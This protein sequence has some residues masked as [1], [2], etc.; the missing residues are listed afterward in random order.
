MGSQGRMHGMSPSSDLLL[1]FDVTQLL[2]SLTA[3][4]AT[5]SGP[6]WHCNVPALKGLLILWE[7]PLLEEGKPSQTMGL[8]VASTWSICP[9]VRR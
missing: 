4:P 9:V 8:F 6:F 3:P 5:G 1:A 2:V 7:A